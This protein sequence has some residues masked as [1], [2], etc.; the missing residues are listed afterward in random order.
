[1]EYAKKTDREAQEYYINVIIKDLRGM[2]SAIVWEADGFFVPN[3]DYFVEILGPVA[4]EYDSGFYSKDG[5]CLWDNTLVLPIPDVF[6][7]YVGLAAFDPINYATAHESNK[8]EFSYYKYSRKDIYP[9]RYYFYGLKGTF[10]KAY[11]DGYLVLTDGVFDTLSF[12]SRGYN[13]WAVLSSSVSE[14]MLAQLRFIKKVIVAMDND[15]A[16]LKMYK[17]LSRRLNNVCCLIQGKTKDADE[18]LKTEYSKR[19]LSKLDD[20]ISFPFPI[21]GICSIRSR[22]DSVSL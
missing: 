1:V 14:Q 21:D 2:D 3:N 7:E 9:H 15:A 8:Y 17:Y 11:E 12:A 6:G 18:I 4:L 13:A 22:F 16:G 5:V 19:Y 10:D 20:I